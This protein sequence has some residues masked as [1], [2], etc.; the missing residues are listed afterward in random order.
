[1]GQTRGFGLLPMTVR[2]QTASDPTK[3]APKVNE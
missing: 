3:Q 1:M 2:F